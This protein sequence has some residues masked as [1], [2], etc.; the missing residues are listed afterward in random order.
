MPAEMGKKRERTTNERRRVLG[1]VDGGK[2]RFVDF[3]SWVLTD[4]EL[5][6]QIS[7]QPDMSG[8][9]GRKNG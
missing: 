3:G 6:R 4:G 5:G 8:Q 2:D 9:N 1:L 7:R